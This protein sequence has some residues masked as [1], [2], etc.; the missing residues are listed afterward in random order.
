MC[1]SSLRPTNVG[2]LCFPAIALVLFSLKSLDTEGKGQM[3]PR[4]TR[5]TVI[6]KIL[7]RAI[8]NR[9]PTQI[10]NVTVT[11]QLFHQIEVESNEIT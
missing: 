2:I 9:P 10:T 5:Q 3:D 4:M 6:A 7:I 8:H 1:T 11:P